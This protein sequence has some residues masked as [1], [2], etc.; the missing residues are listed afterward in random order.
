MYKKINDINELIINKWDTFEL[1]E[2]SEEQKENLL[3]SP[4][5]FKEHIM[6]NKGTIWEE[7]SHTRSQMLLVIAGK[8][9]HVVNGKEFTQEKNDILIVPQNLLHSAYSGRNKPLLVYVFNKK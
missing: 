9:T 6:F 4:H 1:F 5:L 8:L 2:I 7:H 3:N